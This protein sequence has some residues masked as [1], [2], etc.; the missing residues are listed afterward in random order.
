[1]RLGIEARALHGIRAGIGNWTWNLLRELP[2]LIAD[3]EVYL[4]LPEGYE[5]NLPPTLESSFIRRNRALPLMSGH[6]WVQWRAGKLILN[7][8]LDVFWAP[9]TLYPC[10]LI[11]NL[12]VVSSVHDMN[13]ELYPETMKLTNLIAH[14]IWFRRSLLNATRVITNSEGT[15]QRMRTLIGRNADA[16]V[17]PGIDARFNLQV[18][19][20][21][22]RQRYSLDGPYLIFVGTLEPRKN[23]EQLLWAHSHVNNYMENPLQLLLVG[24][25]GWRNRTLIRKLDVGPPH[26]RELGFVPDDD[27]PGLYAGAEALIMPSLYEG[28]GMPAAEARACGTRVVATDIPELHEAAGPDAIYVEPNAE[29]IAEGIRNALRRPRPPAHL[30]QFWSNS[31]EKLASVL[32]DAASGPFRTE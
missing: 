27:L 29:K 21:A 22:V 30:R 5:C 25:R 20:D 19:A 12:P 32:I 17:P 31:A 10:A 15:A 7:D 8:S 18:T 23:L 26:V 3:L 13:A 14:K 1:M 28:Y 9:R 4:Y 11:G 24:Q 6:F 2:K 16:V